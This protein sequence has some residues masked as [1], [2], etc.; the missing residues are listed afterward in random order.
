MR[1]KEQQI[2]DAL[3]YLKKPGQFPEDEAKAIKILSDI[4]FGKKKSAKIIQ[5]IEAADQLAPT[6][7]PWGALNGKLIAVVVGHE[8]GGGAQGERVY[9][10]KVGAHMKALLGKHGAQVW[11]YEHK[12]RAYS[13][14]MAEMKAAMPKCFAAIELH[15]DGY[16]PRPAASG[17]HFQYRGAKELAAAIRDE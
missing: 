13:K 7:V 8:P 6:D 16:A 12:T 2:Q 17:H 1:T 3:W 9:N 11:Y 10:K 5:Q 4:A 14:R 15:Y